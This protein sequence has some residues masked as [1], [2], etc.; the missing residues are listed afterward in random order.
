MLKTKRTKQKRLFL[1]SWRERANELLWQTHPAY[2][3]TKYEARVAW[4]ISKII[5]TRMQENTTYP[6]GVLSLA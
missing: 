3:H 5:S 4:I 1:L 2:Q 6:G